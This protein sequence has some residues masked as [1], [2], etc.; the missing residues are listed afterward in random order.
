ME[1]LLTAYMMT[2]V[3]AAAAALTD[4]VVA[5]VVLAAIPVVAMAVRSWGSDQ[6]EQQW[7]S[8]AADAAPATEAERRAVERLKR[9]WQ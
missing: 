2:T 1:V 4:A 5:V 9:L 3:A 8:R 7:K 6:K